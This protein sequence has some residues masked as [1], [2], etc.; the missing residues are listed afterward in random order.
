MK[1]KAKTSILINSSIPVSSRAMTGVYSPF[2]SV[3]IA[4]DNEE[5]YLL[6]LFSE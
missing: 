2:N 1:D 3:Q 4:L 6:L 5:M